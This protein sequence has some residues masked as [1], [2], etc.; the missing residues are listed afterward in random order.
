MQ[1]MSEQ[2]LTAREKLTDE[3]LD[4][5]ERTATLMGEAYKHGDLATEKECLDVLTGI[6]R[7]LCHS[8]FRPMFSRT[9]WQ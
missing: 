8:G 3:L 6:M 2:Q 9:R 1:Q 5:A 7:T 4:I